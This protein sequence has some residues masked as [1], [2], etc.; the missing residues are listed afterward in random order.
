MGSQGTSESRY[1]GRGPGPGSF[2]ELPGAAGAAGR[3]E[4]LALCFP[5]QAEPGEEDSLRARRC[6]GAESSNPGGAHWTGVGRGPPP[7]PTGPSLRLPGEGEG[8]SERGSAGAERGRSGCRQGCRRPGISGEGPWWDRRRCGYQRGSPGR[9]PPQTSF[10]EAGDEEIGGSE[11]SVRQWLL[12]FEGGRAPSSP[13]LPGVLASLRRPGH[14]FGGQRH[15]GGPCVGADPAEAGRAGV[16]LPG[17]VSG[18]G[19]R[20]EPGLGHGRPPVLPVPVGVLPETRQ[21]GHLAL[22]VH[23]QQRNARPQSTCNPA[24]SLFPRDCLLSCPPGPTLRLDSAGLSPSDRVFLC[25]SALPAAGFAILTV[26]K[27]WK[28]PKCPSVN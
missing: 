25:Y 15:G 20:A 11:P 5:A 6:R 2:E 10:A 24:P 21:L 12:P 17:A 16:H 22:G 9:P 1:Q 19:C 26:A 14:G 13:D 8:R 18:P 7:R 4:G 23:A 27:C 28:P 3:G